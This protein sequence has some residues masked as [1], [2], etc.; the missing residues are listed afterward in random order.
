MLSKATGETGGKRCP[1]LNYNKK[2]I[3]GISGTR[4]C[5]CYF[6]VENQLLGGET[7]AVRLLKNI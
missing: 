3:K 4:R 5:P 1:S 2:K 6:R 7:R